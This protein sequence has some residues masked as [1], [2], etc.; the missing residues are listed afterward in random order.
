[1][2]PLQLTL[3]GFSGV[4][5]GLGRDELRLDLADTTKDAALIA[6]AGQNGSGK[7]TVM[8]NLHP[9]RLMPSRA[10]GL[11]S[12]GFS[13]YEHLCLPEALKELIWEHDGQVYRS[14]LAFRN[15]GT[16]KTEAYLHRRIG[17]RWEV[18]V[19]Q[20]NTVSD[21]KTVTYD[22][23]M[24]AILGNSET[25]FT[26]V[27]S[28]Q[29][30]RPLASYGN[31]EIKAL[32][33][34]L[35]GLE[36]IREA[37]LQAGDVLKQL[38]LALAE[39]R[40]HLATLNALRNDEA[41]RSRELIECKLDLAEIA[42]MEEN[43]R[44]DLDEKRKSLALLLAQVQRDATV[45]EERARIAAQITEAE[46]QA[47]AAGNTILDDTAREQQRYDRLTLDAQDSKQQWSARLNAIEKSIS[48]CQS[49]VAKRGT[50]L[51]A[52]QKLP[53]LADNARQATGE[54][55][56][57]RTQL[58]RRAEI[59]KRLVSLRSHLAGVVEATGTAE[60]QQGQ[61][62]QRCA[63]IAEVPCKGTDLHGKCPLLAD[64][65]EA[66][67]LVPTEEARLAE[68]VARAASLNAEIQEV[69][70]NANEFNGLD[71]RIAAQ[72]QVV[73][74]ASNQL[75]SAHQLARLGDQLEVTEAR[76][77][78]LKN[79][80]AAIELTRVKFCKD[81]E[82]ELLKIAARL[83]ELKQRQ[84]TEAARAERII[85]ALRMALL[86]LPVPVAENRVQMAEAEIAR[87]E[88]ALSELRAKQQVGLLRQGQLEA[89]LASNGAVAADVAILER[90]IAAI[91]E[92]ETQWQ[93]L[94]KALS[95]D[96]LIALCIDDAGPALSSLANELLFA[97]YGARFSVSIQTQVETA[98]REL[99]EGFDITVF[100]SE[101]Q[102]S[103]SVSV[104]SGGERVWINECLTRAIAIYLSRTSGRHYDTLF[105]D[106]SD[107]PLD[108]DRKQQ[109]MQMKRKVRE[110]GGYRAEYFI[111]QS[112]SLLQFA[113]CIIDLDEFRATAQ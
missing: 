77:I 107:G 71:D 72:E 9:Y 14:Q 84:D 75:E 56:I 43:T 109:Y 67:S 48:D 15:N 65:R 94:A 1:M 32:M 25:F 101:T 63:L 73:H 54:L 60:R 28:A 18:V 61:L 76:Q 70:S 98:K 81:T 47:I 30:R 8:D 16:R 19:T 96:G 62:V 31:G 103:K 51:E 57:W 59:A 52:K 36:K 26:S 41:D 90:E 95:N 44:A 99:K 80:S 85:A 29:N 55:Q 23:C 11:T 4:R 66:S 27:F 20:D 78:E 39:R 83:T 82:A 13:Y 3:R 6:I 37:G 50:I 53:A 68:L 33:V 49:L 102:E 24:E 91:G 64:A 17:D 35:L 105:T 93:L 58:A 22:R 69:Q 2:K 88:A 106:E 87:A 38:K 79:E 86:A 34:E 108:H 100:D 7:T 104:M 42:T 113:D 46:G 112:P 5:A 110:L 89:S 74:V 12:G 10:S 92:E 21:G 40:S 97:C 45:V 111:T